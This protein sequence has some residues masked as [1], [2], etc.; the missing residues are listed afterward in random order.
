MSFG[1]SLSALLSPLCSPYVMC[2]LAHADS[3]SSNTSTGVLNMS[4]IRFMASLPFA[5]A[6]SGSVNDG[7]DCRGTV[8]AECGASAVTGE[9][10]ESHTVSRSDEDYSSALD[11]CERSPGTCDFPGQSPLCGDTIDKPDPRSYARGL[12]RLNGLHGGQDMICRGTCEVQMTG[13]LALLPPIAAHLK[14]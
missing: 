2:A 8:G 1:P 7:S 10:S 3:P 14:T 6:R 11:A 12:S 5:D 13:A 4:S 9:E